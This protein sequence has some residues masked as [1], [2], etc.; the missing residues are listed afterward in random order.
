MLNTS[1]MMRAYV[2]FTVALLAIAG[3]VCHADGPGEIGASLPAQAAADVLRDFAAS[4]GAFL[5]AALVKDSY[6]K[7]DLS[8]ILEYPTDTVLV[9][10]LKGSQIRQAFE[11]SVSLYPQHNSSFLQISGFDVSFSKTAPPDHRVTAI[12]A[13]G[14]KLEDGRTYTVAM[15]A[16]LARGALGYFKVWENAKVAKS[17]GRTMEDVLKSKH[18]ADTSPRWSAQG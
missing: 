11:R 1:K 7:D 14:A 16:N 10:E 6:K 13:S 4:D 17:F 15:P 2:R 3:A 9:I 5:A 8:S 12:T 18:Y